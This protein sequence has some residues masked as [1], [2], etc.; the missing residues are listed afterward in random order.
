MLMAL[1]LCAPIA[2]PAGAATDGSALVAAGASQQ[3]PA[4]PEGRIDVNV[5]L[6]RDGG[7][8]YTNPVW[9]AIGVIA[10]IVLVLLIVMAT[11]GGGTTIVKE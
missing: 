3:Q 1:A 6:D 2:A 10:L 4:Q 9:V 7:A 5:D 11:R 8:W